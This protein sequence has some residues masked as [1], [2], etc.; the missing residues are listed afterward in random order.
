MRGELV[1]LAP[2]LMGEED[3]GVIAVLVK[4]KHDVGSHPF[5]W[6]RQCTFLLG[7]NAMTSIFMLPISF[8]SV[9]WKRNSIVPP[10]LD[11]PDVCFVHQPE[12]PSIVE[13]AAYTL[14]TGAFIPTLCEMSV[15]FP[16]Y[17]VCFM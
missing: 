1:Y 6:A 9:E 14:E 10:T 17:D 5:L 4:G 8:P 11:E 7:S 15:I 12:T 16:S 13:S 3:D 2:V